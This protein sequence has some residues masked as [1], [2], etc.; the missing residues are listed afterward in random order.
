VTGK[1][2]I[3]TSSRGK[4]VSLGNDA[5]LT[6][7]GDRRCILLERADSAPGRGQTV[8]FVAVDGQVVGLLGVAD[9]IKQTTDARGAPRAARRRHRRVDGDRRQPG[10]R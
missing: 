9:P 7:L 2:V 6:E 5:L 10:D 4:S 3:G 8:M 1:G